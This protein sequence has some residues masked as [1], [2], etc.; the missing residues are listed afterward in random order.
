[1]PT[2]DEGEQEVQRRVNYTVG[3]FCAIILAVSLAV[4]AAI[5]IPL[6]VLL[7]NCNQPTTSTACS[8]VGVASN[9]CDGTGRTMASLCNITTDC[10]QPDA[11]VVGWAHPDSYAWS[12]P[13]VE[14]SSTT[15]ACVK[16]GN[17]TTGVCADVTEPRM[18]EIITGKQYYCWC[19]WSDFWQSS[20]VTIE[21]SGMMGA[22]GPW[23]NYVAC[24]DMCEG[25]TAAMGCHTL[26]SC[27][28]S[29]NNDAGNC[30]VSLCH[31]SFE[32]DC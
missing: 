8:T 23:D 21:T 1:V 25:A 24:A 30:P 17:T 26:K 27:I 6:G 3:G 18:L 31:I 22:G 15:V 20:H 14:D 2:K 4:A 9:L 7:G 12:G 5:A 13:L 32:D 28:N 19:G 16:S 11:A 10:E 29:C